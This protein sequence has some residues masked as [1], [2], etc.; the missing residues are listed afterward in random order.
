MV[1]TGSKKKG[2]EAISPS[3][4]P[5]SV[6]NI[7]NNISDL[8]VCFVCNEWNDPR[9]LAARQ[10]WISCDCCHHWFHFS[11][12]G[13]SSS[14]Q[15]GKSNFSNVFCVLLRISALAISHPTSKKSF[16]NLCDLLFQ[17]LLPINRLFHQHLLIKR[18]PPL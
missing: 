1:S 7:N 15:V 6:S 4:V 11:C 10:Q 9:S 2:S 12:C 3:K 16:L 14:N 5:L 17:F 13:I 18:P 8:E